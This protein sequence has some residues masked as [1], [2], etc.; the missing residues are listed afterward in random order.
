[1]ALILKKESAFQRWYKKNK[2]VLSEKRKK[3]YAEDLEYRQRAL[4]NSRKRR[5]GESTLTTP[6]DA[7]ISFAE[8]AERIGVSVS[9]LHEWRRKQLLPE[10]KHNNGRLWFSE[11]QVVLLTRLKEVIRVYGKRRG[12]VKWDRLKEVVAS[13]SAEWD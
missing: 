10:P 2:Q 7:L 9:T 4:E 11:K 8:A 12:K 5:R 13:I 1:M 6:P 3:L